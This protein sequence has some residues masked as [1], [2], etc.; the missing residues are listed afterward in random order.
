MSA[1]ARVPLNPSDFS[2]QLVERASRAGLLLDEA[3]VAALWT[4]YSLL[5]RW[6][7]KIN[8]TA[9]RLD[10]VSE[11]AIDR[12]LIEP[13]AAAKQAQGV[14]NWLD[15]GSGGG[16]PAIPMRIVLGDSHLTMV[17]RRERKA[18]FLREVARTLGLASTTVRAEDAEDV[19]RQ[20]KPGSVHLITAR[21]LRLSDELLKATAR[22][23]SAEGRLVL[24]QTDGSRSQ[25]AQLSIAGLSIVSE[26]KLDT[27]RTPVICVLQRSTW[28]IDSG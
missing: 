8:L 2:A 1:D 7:A 26:T 11:E 28:N 25:S 22:A 5:A 24:F 14:E 21:A 20:A 4:Y 10:P 27:S 13:L 3:F 6:N 15:L 23:L 12:L 9:L 18:A 16:S 17:E 19:L